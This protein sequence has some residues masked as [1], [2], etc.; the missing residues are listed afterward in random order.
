MLRLPGRKKGSLTLQQ[1]SRPRFAL[2]RLHEAHTYQAALLMYVGLLDHSPHVPYVSLSRYSPR[3]RG[4]AA[5]ASN[6]DDT[7]ANKLTLFC[8]QA[9]QETRH[10][11]TVKT[12]FDPDIMYLSIQFIDPSVKYV[13]PRSNQRPTRPRTRF[14]A[15]YIKY[16]T[17]RIART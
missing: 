9:C 7:V 14:P 12:Y 4:P 6:I 5:R 3:A 1:A 16:R 13:K 10:L 2:P 15:L 11:C 17:W 8:R